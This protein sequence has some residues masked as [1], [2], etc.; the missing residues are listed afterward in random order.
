MKYLKNKN[1]FENYNKDRR[2]YMK[3]RKFN[4]IIKN[5]F[6]AIDATVCYTNNISIEITY[7]YRIYTDDLIKLCD[8]F[9]GL[10]YSVVGKTNKPI[11]E[12]ADVPYSLL[13][14]LELEEKTKTYN[15]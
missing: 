13:E 10:N 15:I 6:N 7:N 12:V 5:K 1:I 2:D 9:K 3:Y 8:F 11:F 14:Q 4:D